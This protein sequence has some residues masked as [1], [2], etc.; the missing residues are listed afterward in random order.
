MSEP[1]PGET[2]VNDAA[3][4]PVRIDFAD[5]KI[6]GGE[7]FH[8]LYSVAGAN[9]DDDV[10]GILFKTPATKRI[11]LVVTF[12]AADNAEGIINEAPTLADRGDGSDL[13]VFNRERD[14]STA[15]TLESLEDTP[16]A[17]SVTKASE[18]EWTQ[19]GVS[20]GTELDHIFLPGGQGPYVTK[21]FVL[22]AS[23]T[24]AA[25]LQ[26]TGGGLTQVHTLSL[27]WY[28][29]VPRFS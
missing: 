8:A 20:S 16:T 25:Y 29:H 28:E 7:S 15:S 24:Y 1:Q 12:T 17:G 14:S 27:D 4:V 21:R 5:H 18:A 23:T 26:N 11:H 3:G 6:N 9:N 10:T 22:K 19:I 13:A 2:N